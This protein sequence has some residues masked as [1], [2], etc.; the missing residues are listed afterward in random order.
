M[1]LNK[2]DV[3]KFEIINKNTIFDDFRFSRQ[4]PRP[5][6][7][8]CLNAPTAPS[9]TRLPVTVVDSRFEKSGM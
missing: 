8:S 4:L 6:D 1:K 7:V 3:W 9:Q 2:V 5:H